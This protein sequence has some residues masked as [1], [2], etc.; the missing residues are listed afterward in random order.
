MH[1]PDG[2]INPNLASGFGFAA[3]GAIV[4]AINKVKQAVTEPTAQ[5]ALA[6]VGNTV[7][8]ISGKAGK[9]LSRFGQE[10]LVKMGLVSALVFAAQMFNFPIASGTSG[11][12]IGGVLAAVLLGPWGGF[13]AITA[14]VMIQALFYADGGLLVLGTNI[15][16]MALIGA[17]FGYYT[18]SGLRKKL[19]ELLAIGLAAW[20]SVFLAALACSIE[21]WFS[22]TYAIA[23]V[24]PA[25]LSVHAVIGIAEALITI[26]LVQV[27][28]AVMGWEEVK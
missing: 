3:V 14:V 25:M 23:Q 15:I 19:P 4:F 1:L 18:Y 2:F 26:T 7:R 16:N 22:G 12:L 5:A 28:K 11:H 27:S 8:S 13:L 21:L 9:S 20:S 10:Y 24:L 17:V 6:G